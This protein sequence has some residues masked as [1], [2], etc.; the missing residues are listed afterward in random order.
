MSPYLGEIRVF[1]FN[2]A[3]S[4]WA[5]CNGQI[6]PIGE[7]TAL[8]QL[9]G[10]SYGGD[11]VTTFALPNYQNRAPVHVSP[12]LPLGQMGGGQGVQAGA[13]AVT[14]PTLSGNFCIAIQGV[15][16]PRGS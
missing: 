2:Y 1:A 11:G 16:P 7:F 15:F 4:G 14:T 5:P 10:T 9:L 12:D 6:M 8:F 13:G 3:P